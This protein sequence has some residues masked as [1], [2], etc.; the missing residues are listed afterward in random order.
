[1]NIPEYI[2][3]ILNIVGEHLSRGLI[4]DAELLHFIDSSYGLTDHDEIIEFISNGSDAGA[5]VDLLSYPPDILRKSIEI[6]IPDKGIPVELLEEYNDLHAFQ[7]RCYILLNEKKFYLP[8]HD[9]LF[10]FRKI[11]HRLNLDA[12]FAYLS[13]IK[14]SLIGP[15][16]YDIRVLLRKRKFASGTANCRFIRDLIAGYCSSERGSDGEL[17]SLVAIAGDLLNNSERNPYDILSEKR[18]YYKNAYMEA[19]E[20]SRLLKSYSMEFI[21]MKKLQPPLITA[22]EALSI[23]E[24]IFRIISLAHSSG[25]FSYSPLF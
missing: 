1:M 18:E 3:T 6:Y 22:E 25:G 2:R 16:I 23:M 21:M 20:F 4:P 9:S 5:V 7:G 10:C 14:D 11:L 17:M 19:L 12:G 15:D 8:D 13:G 24:K